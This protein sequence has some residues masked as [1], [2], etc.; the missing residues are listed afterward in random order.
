MQA[1]WVV[2]IK[3]RGEKPDV[4][5]RRIR[6]GTPSHGDEVEVRCTDGEIVKGKIVGHHH[7]PPKGDALLGIWTIT[8]NEI[9]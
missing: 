7:E 3:R 1:V 4:Q 6:P 5:Q 8:A 9:F 2:T